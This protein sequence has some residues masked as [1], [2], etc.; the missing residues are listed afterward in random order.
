M[1]FGQDS[2]WRRPVKGLRAEGRCD[3]YRR[4]FAKVYEGVTMLSVVRDRG[5]LNAEESAET[6]TLRRAIS[7]HLHHIVP[8]G[9]QQ[10]PHL[11]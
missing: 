4:G 3:C 1:G 2:V 7:Y 6:S 8:G 5:R 11:S 10:G 9:I